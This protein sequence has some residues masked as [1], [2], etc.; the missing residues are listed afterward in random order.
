MGYHGTSQSRPRYATLIEYNLIV[1]VPPEG[2]H[3]FSS[4]HL[5]CQLDPTLSHL[6][7]LDIHFYSTLR[8]TSLVVVVICVQY[9]V[10]RIPIDGGR[11]SGIIDCSRDPA[12]A[13]FGDVQ[14]FIY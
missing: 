6:K 7:S 10:G 9:F 14:N 1:R 2:K 13:V 3:G 8:L 4:F 11:N 12:R 5:P